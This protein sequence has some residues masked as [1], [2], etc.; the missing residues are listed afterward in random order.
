MSWDLVFRT[1]VGTKEKKRVRV[2]VGWSIGT[3]E[4]RVVPRSQTGE[5]GDVP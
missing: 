5:S 2:W 4:E 1:S 3:I